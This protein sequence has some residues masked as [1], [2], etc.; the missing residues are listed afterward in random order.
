MRCLSEIFSENGLLETKNGIVQNR[1]NIFTIS[2][3]DLIPC[4]M[5]IA[6]RLG[7]EAMGMQSGMIHEKD[8]GTLELQLS[9]KM[10]LGTVKM[11][12]DSAYKVKIIARTMS[13]MES[14]MEFFITSFPITSSQNLMELKKNIMNTTHLKCHITAISY[15]TLKKKITEIIIENNK[16]QLSY[17]EKELKRLF[18][19]VML[20]QEKKYDYE[21]ITA[22]LSEEPILPIRYRREIE[23]F[24]EIFLDY[25]MYLSLPL[26]RTQFPYVL[27]QDE[28]QSCVYFE[29]GTLKNRIIFKE[30]SCIV[31]AHSMKEMA[32]M[33]G[34]Y[35]R[36]EDKEEHLT[37][38][39]QVIEVIEGKTEAGQLLSFLEE[40]KENATRLITQGSGC[41][42][43]EKKQIEQQYHIKMEQCQKPDLLKKWS[44]TAE[45]EGTLFCKVFNQEI[46]SRVKEDDS[47][48]II[49]YLSEDQ[50]V[51]RELECQ[52]KEQLDAM[53]VSLQIRIYRT[54]KSAYSWLEEYIV[55]QLK[56]VSEVK[57]IKIYFQYFM[58]E[59]GDEIFEDESEPNY[60]VHQ[61]KP[62]KWFDIPTRWLQ[63]IFPVDEVFE[64][65]LGI[66][67]EQI[68]FIRC[69]NQ[70][71]VYRIVAYNEQDY[72]VF[73]EEF[74]PKWI[75]KYYMNTFP[76]IGKTHVST[77]W[78]KA[79]IN[80]QEVVN[81]RVQTDTEAVWKQLEERIIPDI[82]A[83][84][85]SLGDLKALPKKQPL[86]N[87]LEFSIQ[88]SEM[89]YNTQIRQERISTLEAM[90]EDIYFYILDWFKTFGER[91]C[92]CALDNVGLIIPNLENRKYQETQIDAGLYLDLEKR[93]CF[94]TYSKPYQMKHI[95]KEKEIMSEVK[96]VSFN[97]EP[98][99]TI[100]VK[101]IDDV[102]LKKRVE[103][104]QR[105]LGQKLLRISVSSPVRLE[106]VGDEY[107]GTI[108]LTTSEK[109]QTL[110]SDADKERIL[111][112]EVIDYSTYEQLLAYYENLYP[113]K[114]KSVGTTYMGKKIYIIEV[115]NCRKNQICN[116]QK[117]MMFKKT[118]LFSGRHHGNEA[119]SVNAAFLL[120]EQLYTDVSLQKDLET[121]NVI[122]LPWENIDGGELH[123]E[124]VQKHPH[125]LA[126][127]ARY[128]SAGFE[129]RKDYDN[130]DSKYG[131]AKVVRHLWD[132]WLFDVITDNHGFEGHELIQ[133]FSGYISPW[134]KGFWIPK[135]L[136]YGY[137]WYDEA[138]LPTKR[139]GDRVQKSVTKRINDDIEIHA[140]NLEHKERFYKYAEKWFPTVFHAE[141]I[142]DVVFYWMKSDK[143]RRASNYNLSQPNITTLDW[144]TE[145]ADE[146]VQGDA[147]WLNVRAHVLSDLGLLDALRQMPLLI[148]SQV[149]NCEGR[150]QYS[151]V[152]RKPL[153]KN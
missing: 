24:P 3:L 140:L 78:I 5:N 133:P 12:L 116:Q 72:P 19:K 62:Q 17:Q 76:N 146:T 143:H 118:I 115:L 102:R 25:V 86:F 94:F 87:K 83:W 89:D 44:T 35:I 130:E 60:G 28:S 10:E 96:T 136:Y 9:T 123:C 82:Q 132:K 54:F 134:Y 104:F 14:F 129:F 85:Y 99:I 81:K 68:D 56:G 114:V 40:D 29:L 43:L 31:Q 103:L 149:I 59:D 11:V 105:L 22:H 61:D 38:Q 58:N 23:E 48:E 84:L 137:F 39:R 27:Y 120:L 112:N 30:S 144:T 34:N 107:V 77:G 52:I 150:E 7:V 41:V 100:Q 26:F 113:I 42:E 109:R 126:H 92:G 135:S 145:V 63:E 127:P 111:K 57:K 147:M 139:F 66:E 79:S 98:C 88:M 2:N 101:N 45:W 106:I 75:E 71:Q 64:R 97:Q 108:V 80:G 1:Q 121:T 124:I 128:N 53:G 93:P 151:K 125:W 4:Y 46:L 33:L 148:K 13:E 6:H 32:V 8:Q 18:E 15:D 51:R 20:N 16:E 67:R 131:E 65:D 49:G 21:N 141:T 138:I 37:L 74:N 153:V 36:W 119:S 69:D 90:Q 73:E 152:R 110:L 55:P 142:D 122:F 91:N 117:L 50:D 47:V 70:E 95:L